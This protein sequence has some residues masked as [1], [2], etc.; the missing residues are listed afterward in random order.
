MPRPSRNRAIVQR[1]NQTLRGWS[2]YFYYANS[3]KVFGDVRWHAEER[4][5]THLRK[6]HKVRIR[7][8]GYA[9]FDEG[10]LVM[11]SMGWLLRHRRTK[12]AGTDRLIPNGAGANSLLYPDFHQA[13]P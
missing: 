10:G 6:R 9:R 5:R 3:T 1:L 2:G 7:Y 12:G 11:V 4:L 13:P 8:F